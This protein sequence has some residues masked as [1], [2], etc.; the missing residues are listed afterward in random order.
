MTVSKYPG[1]AWYITKINTAIYRVVF[2]ICV[3]SGLGLGWG[4]GRPTLG[5]DGRRQCGEPL[6][7]ATR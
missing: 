2:F 4:W 3:C 1:G 6:A 5:K 7:K